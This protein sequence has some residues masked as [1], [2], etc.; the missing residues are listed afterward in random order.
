MR[1]LFTLPGTALRGAVL[2]GLLAAGLGLPFS[3]SAQRVL[4]ADADSKPLPAAARRTAQALGRYRMVTVQLAN[5]RAALA[6]AANSNNARS[7]GPVVS[8]P[9]PDGSSGRFR[10]TETQVMAPALAAR[11]PA[12]KTYSA[13]GIDDPTATAYLDVSK[14]GLHAMILSAGNTVYVDPAAG[15]PEHLV[16]YKRD[17]NDAAL[18]RRVCLTQTTSVLSRR[19]GPLQGGTAARSNG[20]QL[21]TYRLAMACTGEYAAKKGG[22]T[23]GALAGIVAS[24]NRVSGVYEKELSI[25]LQLIGN[26][27]QLIFLDPATDPYTNESTEATLNTNQQVTDQRIGPANYDI[28]HVFTTDGGGLAGLGVVCIG[29]NKARATTGLPNPIGDAF[30]IDFVAHEMGHQFGANHT[31]NSNEAG[32]CNPG[33]RAGSAAYEPGS[34]STIMSYAGIC[35]PQNLQANSDAYFHTWSYDEILN[36][37]TTLGACAN[38]AGT[39]NRPPTV[40]AGANYTIPKGTPF[41]LTGSAAD[42][43]GDALTYCW[44]ELDL[45]P[46]GNPNQPQ[47]NAPIFRSFPPT[48]NPTRVFPRLSA[49]LSNTSTIGELL[50]QYGR[51]LTFRLTVRDNRT[52][53]GGTNYDAVTVPVADNAGPFVVTA[54]NTNVTWRTTVPQQVT[55]DVA[56]TTAAPV[57]AAQV[58]ILLSV[59]GG[60]TYPYTLA[61]GTP[62]DGAE[63]VTVPAGVPASGQVRLKV[64]GTGNVF[65]DISNQNFTLQTPSGPGFFLSSDCANSTQAV[66]PGAS[67]SCSLSVGQVLGFA[68][69]VGLSATGVPAGVSVSFGST[70]VAAGSSTTLAIS[71]AA[72]AAAGTYPITVV[73]TGGGATETQV[74]NLI[75]RNSANVPPTLQQP[76]PNSLRALPQPTFTWSAIPGA[77]SYDLQVATDAGFNNVVISQAGLQTNTYTAA[78]ALQQN[79]R[80]YWR[81]RGTAECGVGNW[82]AGEQFYV[83]RL[84]CTTYAPTN[85]PLAIANTTN[86][87]AIS[88]ITVSSADVV[89]AV[90]VRDLRIT[91]RD[92]GEL[93]LELRGPDNTRVRLAS[94]P[95]PGNANINASFDDAAATGIACPINTG[96]TYQPE[97]PLAAFRGSAANGPWT[98]HVLD[99]APGNA[100]SLTNWALELCTVQDAVTSNRSAKQLQGVAVYPNP[101]T[102][103][104]ELTIDNNLRGS[105][106]VRVTDAVGRTVLAEQLTKGAG[107]LRHTLDLG[108][109]TQGV[110]HLQLELPGGGTAIEKL[111]KL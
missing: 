72:T 4:W 11:Y 52:G 96:G 33:T 55:W 27:D 14:A 23:E 18:A 74:I 70:Q 71:S 36:H 53:G 41:E 92:L 88:T 3:A 64:K 99:V 25:R 83:G 19:L 77:T 73:G 111:V 12:I 68:G 28:G 31:F 13:Q 2:R 34:G 5:L 80:Y 90:R 81:V 30:D 108:K 87:T 10:V 40:D 22:T 75:I 84:G 24:V 56:N 50:P 103:R 62:N 101:S 105:L 66:C 26:T 58:D 42:A 38:T 6:P 48:T 16:F 110:Y 59:D 93:V 82:S 109:L 21:R 51:T 47:G 8:L 7:A 91:H 63:Q 107:Q 104:F 57:S 100:G 29:N 37:V 35:P 106:Q 69:Q 95:C 39:G 97:S 79:G 94:S 67:V 60:L 46:A 86:A 49:L 45:G 43:D 15:G 102:G 54:P 17:I 65:F 76:A 78:T 61:A 98:L 32:N 9:L 85:L 1:I 44:E 89:S 20:T